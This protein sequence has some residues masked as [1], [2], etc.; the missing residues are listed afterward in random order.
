MSANDETSHDWIKPECILLK[1]SIR[2]GLPVTGICLG[3]QLIAKALGGSVEKNH[4]AELGWHRIFLTKIGLMDPIL[5]AAGNDP[6]VYHWHNDTF[7]LPPDG[8][9]LA[10]S[11]ACERQ[12]FRIGEAAYA[13]QFHPEADAQLVY[14]WLSAQETDDE[15]RRA[16]KANN[17]RSVQDQITQ[18]YYT[19]TGEQSSLRITAAIGALFRDKPSTRLDPAIVQIAEEAQT[20]NADVLLT[21][22]GSGGLGVGLTG[23][24]TGSFILSSF[25][26]LVFQDEK[27]SLWPIRLDDVTGL[28]LISKDLTQ[29]LK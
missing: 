24:I 11:E 14:Q 28:K 23:K 22:H 20:G 15:I 29:A 5:S 10:R 1:N 9:L 8:E 17:E 21:F 26:F 4:T 7:L 6:L 27:N 2:A 18:R 3:G 25:K 19:S 16:I 13:F 12:A